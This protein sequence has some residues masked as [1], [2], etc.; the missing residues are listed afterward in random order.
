M[1]GTS[2][3]E[4]LALWRRLESVSGV[5][6]ADSVV[7]L[8]SHRYMDELLIYGLREKRGNLTLGR[9]ATVAS[10]RLLSLNVYQTE[11]R[12]SAVIRTEI[13]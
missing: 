10:L 5:I 11:M 4:S 9:W 6:L 2:A 8:R 12:V 1:Q 3:G 7:P 13:T